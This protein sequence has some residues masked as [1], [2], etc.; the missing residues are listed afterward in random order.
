MAASLQPERPFGATGVCGPSGHGARN[1][2][3]PVAQAQHTA[4]IAM[5]VLGHGEFPN[6]E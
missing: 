6:I 3:A 4:I 2:F 5:K 1:R